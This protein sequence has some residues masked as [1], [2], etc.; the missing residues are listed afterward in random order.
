METALTE[1]QEQ[2]K[3]MKLLQKRDEICSHIE[4]TGEGLGLEIGDTDG[5]MQY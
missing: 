2:I 3:S 5:S 4:S 1:S